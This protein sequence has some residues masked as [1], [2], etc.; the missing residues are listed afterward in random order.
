M[1]TSLKRSKGSQSSLRI[2]TY[3]FWIKLCQIGAF[4]IYSNTVESD[5]NR[6]Y[7]QLTSDNKWRMV[8]NDAS[9]TH[10]Q[11][12]TNRLF[13]DLNA[14][15]H[16]VVRVDTTQA[17][18]TD[19]VRLYVNGVQETSFDQTDYP[20]Q[21]DDLK[22]FQG[23]QTNREYINNIYGG[24][25]L[26]T[27][28]Y[29][30]H[31]HYT[32]G[33]SYGPDTFGS[34]DAT[35]GEWKINTSPTVTYGNQGFFMFKDDASLSDDSGNS[36]NWSADSGTVQ[37][38]ED[39]PSDTFNTWNRNL[40]NNLVPGFT[41]S[42]GNTTI[43][44]ATPANDSWGFSNLGAFSG[45][46]YAEFKVSSFSDNSHYIGVKFFDGIMSTDN[47][48]N[49]IFL[50]FAKS[51]NTNQIYSG[52]TSGF[53][54]SNL[55]SFSSGDIIGIAVDIGNGTVNFTRNG[56]QYATQVTGQ[57]SNFA[58]KQLQFACFGEGH[59]SQSGRTFTMNANFGNGYFGTTAIT[60][61]GTNASN[62]GKFE[63][64][65]PSGFTAFSTKGIN[66]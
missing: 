38:S 13:R 22:I 29:L 1:T 62:I 15:Y 57:A 35:T 58:G 25:A 48:K 61:E 28:F 19:R 23:G 34:T 6:G 49:T 39:N 8:D 52:F 30:S 18:S 31:F 2:G 63:Y 10:I 33:Q 47:F 4:N 65:V 42:T 11:L 53:L 54:Q 43:A 24:S 3:S 14:W 46:Y 16:M 17:T 44:F 26:A 7:F 50:R 60:S 36:N 21:N 51:S 56:A 37:K 64:D 40:G 32:D 45:K 41:F 12:R 27:N 20:A 5:N 9:G 55:D 59:G 66:S